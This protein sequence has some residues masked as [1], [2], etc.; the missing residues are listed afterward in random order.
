MRCGS[1]DFSDPPTM[2]AWTRNVTALILELE[3]TFEILKNLVFSV[4]I[5]ITQTKDYIQTIVL[6]QSH[7]FAKAKPKVRLANDFF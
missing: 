4:C 6:H 1:R 5:T 3:S 2:R 7:S